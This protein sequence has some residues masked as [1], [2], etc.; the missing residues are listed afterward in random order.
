MK[1]STRPS[2]SRNII[3]FA[4]VKARKQASY[5]DDTEDLDAEEARLLQECQ[6]IIG[7]MEKEF[8]AIRA[9][10]DR[11]LLDSE[12]VYPRFRFPAW[13][14]L[15]IERLIVIEKSNHF[16]SYVDGFLG[17]LADRAADEA[18]NPPLTLVE[19]EV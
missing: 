7:R 1:R 9:G 17:G 19:T 11:A 13:A 6:T 5:E 4:D 8:A 15:C 2:K 16:R 3:S 18:Q 14:K 10:N 12:R